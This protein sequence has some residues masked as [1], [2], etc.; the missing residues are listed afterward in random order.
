M[1]SPRSLPA[2]IRT[3]RL[4]LRRQRPA[5]ARLIKDA[6]DSSLAR[7]RA[8]VAWA[9]T[10]PWSLALQTERLRV[11][12]AEFDAGTA[13]AF[14]I[15]D[16]TETR[17]LGGVALEPAEPSLAALVGPKAFET[18][19]WLRDDAVGRGF[20]TEATASLVQLAFSSLAARHVV[21]CHDPANFASAGVPR[22]LGF[23]SLDPVTDA[24]LPG[25]LAADGTVRRTTTIWVLDAIAPLR[26]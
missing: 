10:A 22:R 7:L 18:G 20:A 23:R 21:V 11:S 26:R 1:P 6:V 4:V 13:W 12:A 24:Q 9:Q 16:A 25:R 14:S 15:F 17:V 3:A 2:R 8:S 5:D 19:Y